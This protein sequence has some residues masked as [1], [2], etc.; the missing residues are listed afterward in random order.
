MQ[1]AELAV[2]T[3]LCS[4]TPASGAN[5]TRV[6]LMTFPAVSNPSVEYCAPNGSV[7]TV[8]YNTATNAQ[9]LIVPFSDTGDFKTSVTATQLNPNSNLVKALGGG[10][11][12]AGLQDPGGQSTYYGGALAAAQSYFT[13]A[14]NPRPAAQKV[15]FLLSDGDAQAATG[16]AN[17]C[18]TAVT[19][20]QTA[21]T[22][23]TWVFSVA[24]NAMNSGTCS[25]DTGIYKGNACKAM[26]NIASS[27][28]LKPDSSKFFA[29]NGTGSGANCTATNTSFPT[30]AATFKAAIEAFTAARL[31]SMDCVGST[32]CRLP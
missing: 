16:P 7:K 23:G 19:N 13:T 32:T 14:P 15:I 11:G 29:F 3:L 1:A 17:E 18:Q 27:P 26:Q 6:A 24:Y 20:A 10:S 9:Y 4:F 28:G 30:L 8:P 22:A 25:K 31:V 12:C 2:Q 5:G 21:A